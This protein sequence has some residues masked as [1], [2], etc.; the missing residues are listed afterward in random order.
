MFAIGHTRRSRAP[1]RLM[2]VDDPVVFRAGLRALLEKQRGA[3]VVDEAG[4][5]DDAVERVRAVRPD[6]VLM[7]LATTGKEGLEATRRTVA[8]GIGTTGLILTGLPQA[9]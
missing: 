6:V 2:L 5:G 4:R 3:T 1:I 7:D 9:H 8:L